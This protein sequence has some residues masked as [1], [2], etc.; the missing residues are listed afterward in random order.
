MPFRS[1][2]ATLPPI[3]LVEQPGREQDAYSVLLSLFGSQR[4]LATTPANTHEEIKLHPFN[5]RAC[6]SK[7]LKVGFN[8]LI[9]DASRVGAMQVRGGNLG[10]NFVHCASEELDGALP[11]AGRGKM[12]GEGNETSPGSSGHRSTLPAPHLS[13]MAKRPKE[14]LPDFFSGTT[15]AP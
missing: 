14:A 2:H 3:Q 1:G 4:Q 7:V 11:A 9:Q 12:K 13:A 6:V 15:M 5:G 10:G 8:A